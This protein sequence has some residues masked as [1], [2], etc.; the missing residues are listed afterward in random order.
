MSIRQIKCWVRTPNG[1]EQFWADDF[2]DACGGEGQGMAADLGSPDTYTIEG[3]NGETILK[4]VDGEIV[5]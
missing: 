1:D 3:P 5:V 4:V 2:D